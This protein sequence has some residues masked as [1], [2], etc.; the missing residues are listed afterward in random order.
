[1]VTTSNHIHIVMMIHAATLILFGFCITF[2]IT[3]HP[4]INNR[5]FLF[6]T[7]IAKIITELHTPHLDSNLSDSIMILL[8]TTNE[9]PL[10]D[11]F[12]IDHRLRSLSFFPLD[13]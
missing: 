9:Q 1:M 4:T 6:M 8:S 13:K 12:S 11:P 5:T 3:C 10:I 2:T 7:L